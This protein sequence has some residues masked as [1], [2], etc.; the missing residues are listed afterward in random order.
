MGS[1]IKLKDSIVP[2]INC[3]DI[4]NIIKNPNIA[5]ASW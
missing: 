4:T 1:G 5:T 3:E 2:L